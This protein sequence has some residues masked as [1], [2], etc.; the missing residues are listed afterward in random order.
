MRRPAGT[1]RFRL[2][3]PAAPAPELEKRSPAP[4]ADPQA[5]LREL[6]ERLAGE[7][8][9]HSSAVGAVREQLRL[10]EAELA[11]FQDATPMS[12]PRPSMWTPRTWAANCVS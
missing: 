8:E 3:G 2:D 6:A 9:Q 7:P 12:W 11:A 5:R 10:A 1:F 4:G